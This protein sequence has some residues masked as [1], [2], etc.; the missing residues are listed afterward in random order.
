[1]MGT[2]NEH[3]SEHLVLIAIRTWLKRTM[4]LPFDMLTR[5]Q[6]SHSGAATC[7]TL[8]SSCLDPV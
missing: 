2:T 5:F 3:G 4:M 8:P 6:V 1:M 7:L